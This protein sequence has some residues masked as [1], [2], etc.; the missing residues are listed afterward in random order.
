MCTSVCVHACGHVYH[1]RDQGQGGLH[2]GT[3][4]EGKDRGEGG[5][6]ENFRE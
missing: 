6:E 4:E 2:I 5:R 1:P 3:V